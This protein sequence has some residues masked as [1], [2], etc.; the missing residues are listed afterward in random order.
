MLLS[1]SSFAL[2]HIAQ[3]T[4]V[5]RNF[6]K[7]IDVVRLRHLYTVDGEGKELKKPDKY[8]R[9]DFTGALNKTAGAAN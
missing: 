7:D 2:K 8:S 6:V 4:G 9:E 3:L 1:I 5:N